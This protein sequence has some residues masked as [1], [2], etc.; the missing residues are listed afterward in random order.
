[1]LKPELSDEEVKPIASVESEELDAGN[2]EHT[3]ADVLSETD[4]AVVV[5]DTCTI[6]VPICDPP[7]D[8]K[9]VS[10]KAKIQ[11]ILIATPAHE[12]KT[13]VDDLYY[14]IFSL[15][16]PYEMKCLWRH[17]SSY[18]ELMFFSHCKTRGRVF[19]NQER[20]IRNKKE[21]IFRFDL[22]MQGYLMNFG[23]KIF[24]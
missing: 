23:F 18:F 6:A 1:M 16:N 2:V 12:P 24:I 13:K 17:G 3:C 14:E 7:V 15:P 4:E 11:I 5:V 21:L 22:F 8:E 10:N 9:H 20:M 19:S